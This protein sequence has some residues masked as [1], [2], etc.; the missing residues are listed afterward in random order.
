MAAPAYTYTLT[1]G[2]TADASQVMQDFNDILNGVTD[3]TKDLSINAITAAGTATF[4]GNVNIGNASG[5]DLTITASLAST[6][7]I[8]ATNTYNIGSATL[9]LAGIYFGTG[10]TQT[11]RVV[12]ASSYAGALT[13]TLP[14]LG[15]A[16]TFLFLEGAQT[17]SGTKTF[18]ANPKLVA[19]YIRLHTS[20]GYGSTN[21]FIRRFS[22]TVSSTGSDITYADSV[23]AGGSFTIVTKGLYS[24]SYT[25]NFSSSADFGLS[26]NSTQLTTNI[27]SITTADRLISE[28]TIG[29]NAP[30]AVSWTGVLNANDVVR[31]HGDSTTDGSAAR[32]TINFVLLHPLG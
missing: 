9:G 28:R 8:K 31:A 11:A 15:T 20:N 29:G 5:D 21:T 4:N 17:V 1:N 27:V 18:S 12:A 13:Y 24:I 16:G 2:T 32:T 25:D 22:T 19:S 3:G 14:D 30:A 6:I 10:S 23:T 26:L 7:A